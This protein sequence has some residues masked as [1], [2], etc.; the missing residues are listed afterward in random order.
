M[1]LKEK[2]MNSARILFASGSIRRIGSSISVHDYPG[3]HTR[4][5]RC[6]VRPIRSMAL[7]RER[8]SFG[9]LVT[10]VKEPCSFH[11]CMIHQTFQRR[12][13]ELWKGHPSWRICGDR[14]RQWRCIYM[15]SRTCKCLFPYQLVLERGMKRSW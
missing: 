12:R 6:V 5:K 15:L 10:S 11:W 13:G 14:R 2:P 8:P 4:S 1:R 3:V 7:N 9:R